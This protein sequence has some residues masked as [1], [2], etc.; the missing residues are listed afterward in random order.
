MKRFQFRLERILSLKEQRE[1]QA[2]IEQQQARAQWEQARAEWVRM[3]EELVRTAASTRERLRQA[4]ALGT[5]RAYYEQAARLGELLAA[6][7]QRFT[8]AEK[9][10]Q[11]ASRLRIQA[12]QEVET[13]RTLRAHEWQNFRKEANR[14]QQNNLDE[15]GLQRWLRARVKGTFGTPDIAEGEGS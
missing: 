2:E 4:A 11:E 9:R 8:E 1:R 10:L 13:L 12:A 6:A 5:W 14:R 15:L 7:Q 3:E